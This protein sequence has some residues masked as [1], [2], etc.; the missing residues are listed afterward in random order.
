MANFTF[1]SRA[2]SS[3]PSTTAPPWFRFFFSWIFPFIFTAIG[4]GL[5]YFGVLAYQQAKASLDWP[6]VDGTIVSSEFQSRRGEDSTFYEAE[7]L[8]EYTIEGVLHSSNRVA[9]GSVSSSDPSGARQTVNRYPAGATVPVS[10]NPENSVESVLE[11]GVSTATYFLPGV[12]AIFLVVGLF[13]Y[14][15]L[16]RL[17]RS[18]D[19]PLDK[20]YAHPLDTHRTTHGFED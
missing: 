6:R 8:Y 10:V 7:V 19:R 13:L 14:A 18:V 11:P 17:F 15:L 1:T 5:L 12:G 9:F 20:G 4:A 3:S 16:P 2:S